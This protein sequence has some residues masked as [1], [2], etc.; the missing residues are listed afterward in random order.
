M[1]QGT[2]TALI[3]PFK[4]DASFDAES[5]ARIVEHQLDQGID[6]LVP[7]GTTGE[8]PTVSHKE[9]LQIIEHV[10]RIVGGKIPV[11]AGTGSNATSEAIEMT[12]QAKAI[13]AFASLQVAP[14]YNK[15]SQEGFYRHYMNIADK[16]DFP[17][18][19]YNIPGRTGKNISIDTILRLAKHPRIIAVKE[20]S[21]DF[22]QITQ[23]IL[24]AP[25]HF[26]ILSGDDAISLPLIALGAKGIIS[27]AS[28]II[29]GKIKHIIDKALCG[30]IETA[31]KSFL[32]LYPFIRIL[33]TESNPIPVK[34]AMH[35]AGFCE[36]VFRLPLYPMEEKKKTDLRSIM[37]QLE[38]LR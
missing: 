1:L 33:F 4:K 30:E 29:P 22:H 32:Y 3:T 17:L 2:F 20:A 16:T 13:G 11:I 38:I 19:I 25:E 8:S 12:K 23:L 14:Y 9:N 21:G 27:V 24:H 35:I 18:I 26:S 28:N 5:L 15:P 34:Y 37:T 36:E 10:V 31:R 7:V 6:G